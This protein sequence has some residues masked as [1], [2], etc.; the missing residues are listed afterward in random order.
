MTYVWIIYFFERGVGEKVTRYWLENLSGNVSC[1]NDHHQLRL[2]NYQ[3]SGQTT[4]TA[5]ECP[6]C[7][8]LFFKYTNAEDAAKQ[9]DINISCLSVQERKKINKLRVKPH[10]EQK[11]QPGQ[12]K[13][14]ISPERARELRENWEARQAKK[15]AEQDA[16]RLAEEKERARLAALRAKRETLLKQINNAFINDYFSAEEFYLAN[17]PEKLISKPDFI[18]LREKYVSDWFENN[19]SESQ[20]IPDHNQVIAIGATPKNIEVVARAGSGKTATIVNR[21]RFLTENCHVDPTSILL[22]AFNRKAAEELRGKIEGLLSTHQG[23]E[24]RMPHVMTFHALAYS[25]VHPLEKLI[26]DDEEA[27]SLE[28]SRTV[29]SIIDDMLLDTAWAS[30]I[31][32]VMLDHFKGNWEAIEAGG[33]NLSKEERLVY[34]HSLPNRTLKGDYV[35]SYGEK[36][37]ADLLFEHDVEYKYE[38]AC[39]WGD[40]T[41]YRPDFTIETAKN[42][43][44]IIEYFGLVGDPEY[45]LQTRK[46]RAY[47]KGKKTP[48][49]EVYPSDVVVD[50]D[51]FTNDFLET[52]KENGISYR[53]LSTDEIWSKIKDR[54]IDDFTRAVK[55]FIGRCRK[56]DLSATELRDLISD[57]T[58]VTPTE[59]SFLEI[60]NTIYEK[61]LSTIQKEHLED[62]DGLMSRAIACIEEGQT[63][64]GKWDYRGDLRN[65]SFI[66]VDEYQDFSFL[67]DRFL[68]AIR[69][70]CPESSIF[71]VG[72]DWQAINAFAGSDVKYF[73]EFTKLH[74]D[75][76]RYYLHSNYRSKKE[77]VAVSTKLMSSGDSDIEAIQKGVGTVRVGYLNE[78]STTPEEQHAHGSDTYTPAILR[79]VSDILEQNKRVVFLTRTNDRLPEFFTSRVNVNGTKQEVFLA[80]IQSFFSPDKKKRITA[81]TTH[82]YKGKEEDAVIILD[83][84]EGFY[85]LIHPTWVFQRVFGDSVR[86]LVE[87]ERRLFYVALSR[88]KD[89]L[90]ILT[91]KKEE[92]P[93]LSDLGTLPKIDW[94]QYRPVKTDEAYIKIGVHNQK[95]Y[96]SSPT[97]AIKELLKADQY[98]WDAKRKAWYRFYPREG[99]DISMVLEQA[100]VQKGSHVVLI[101]Y[102]E[103][104]KKEDAYLIEDEAITQLRVD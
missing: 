36:V 51:S 100:W 42:S 37:I 50:L 24:N 44:V 102:N 69:S 12:K 68:S 63:E 9:L 28:L 58:C 76:R 77:I 16:R 46:K 32:T 2:I 7:G 90:Y 62:F 88:A 75:S 34:L 91:T 59:D 84:I 67:F 80:S 99:F 86:K 82:K 73:Q 4:S 35:K 41:V 78:F 47:W 54:A 11:N 81:S 61:Y 27:G 83:A 66:M 60:A 38:K 65:L 92:S 20:I 97:H 79:L 55:S 64:F 89:D 39:Y 13:P 104:N 29:Q 72:D 49:V 94:D 33:H 1:P 74:K 71:C 40:G 6:F 52:L 57:Y 22:M 5:L 48:L 21:F 95:G 15:K 93:F 87:E 101:Q 30:K 85:P 10:V 18:R 45:D 14:R 25:I 70:V 17:D 56:K 3:R 98:L 31:K 8:S 53:N 23:R 103:D 19:S 43:Q 26:Y 96:G